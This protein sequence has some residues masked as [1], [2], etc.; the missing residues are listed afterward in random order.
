MAA[1]RAVGAGAMEAAGEAP[2]SRTLLIAAM[3]L[4][5]AGPVAAGEGAGEEAVG[6][7]Y[8]VPELRQRAEAGDAGAR[9]ELG[10]MYRR[11][12]GVAQD[13]GEAARWFRLAAEQGH[14]NALY[15]LG[16]MYRDGQGVP[17]NDILAHMWFNLAI[18]HAGPGLRL[19]MQRF[20]N[21]VAERMTPVQIQEA[22]RLALA[23]YEARQ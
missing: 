6:A 8:G 12:Y 17:R 14:A 21:A 22:Q 13:H 18:A 20:R 15:N 10:L 3:V 11:G 4:A 19:F 5:L 2:M 23:W 16:V 1:G 9:N 7:P